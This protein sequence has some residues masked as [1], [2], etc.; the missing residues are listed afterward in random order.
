[1][2]GKEPL[3]VTS[4]QDAQVPVGVVRPVR[5]EGD[6]GVEHLDAAGPHVPGEPRGV[7]EH[8]G[9]RH[10]LPDLRVQLAAHRGELVLELDEEERRPRGVDA[11]A[12]SA[13]RRTLHLVNRAL[14]SKSLTLTCHF[15]ALRV[16]LKISACMYD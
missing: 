4:A 3:V 9:Q 12:A 11:Q 1:M 10:D 6:G 7:L 14:S 15:V 16:S 8:A 2:P 13:R 5:G